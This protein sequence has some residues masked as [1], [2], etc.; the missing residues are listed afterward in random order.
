[1]LVPSTPNDEDVGINVEVMQAANDIQIKE[2][3]STKSP[4]NT[5]IVNIFIILSR[6][7]LSIN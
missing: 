3:L 7:Y 4:V 1:M 2:L 6:T 5:T